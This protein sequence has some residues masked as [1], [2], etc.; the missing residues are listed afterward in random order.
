MKKYNLNCIRKSMNVKNSIR[1]LS[2]YKRSTIAHI[3]YFFYSILVINISYIFFLWLI[4]L[5]KI[6]RK[7]LLDINKITIVGHINLK[8]Y[9]CKPN[10]F[11]SIFMIANVFK[12]K[13]IHLIYFSWCKFFK[14][15]FIIFQYKLIRNS[16][17]KLYDTV[18]WTSVSYDKTIT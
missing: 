12:R 15:D 3:H 13:Q 7:I 10:L 5:S 4:F 14:S 18:K 6:F 9:F 8:P 11:I 16:L 2:L 17:F 1:N